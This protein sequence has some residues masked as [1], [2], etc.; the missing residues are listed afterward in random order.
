M[1][2]EHDFGLKL[3][4]LSHKLKK[5]LNA[6]LS[7]LGITGVQ[8]RILHYILVHRTHD[9]VFQRDI[10][11]VFGLSRST[12]TGILQLLERDGLIRRESVS[13][14]ARL[15]SIVPTEKAA[16]I[17]AQVLESI[18]EIEQKLIDGITEN[19]QTIFFSVIDRMSCNLDN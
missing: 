2:R 16:R 8:S 11:N 19:E 3:N 17:D 18:V 9:P 14:D 12:A 15:K 1:D 7:K 13:S 6:E 10:E 4:I 5:R